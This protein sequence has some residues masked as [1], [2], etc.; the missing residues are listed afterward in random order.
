MNFEFTETRLF[1]QKLPSKSRSLSAHWSAKERGFV[2][3]RQV[4]WSSGTSLYRLTASR[5][6]EIRQDEV[7][8]NGVSFAT[9]E[10]NR[11]GNRIRGDHAGESESLPPAAPARR[12]AVLW[13]PSAAPVLTLTIGSGSVS[14]PAG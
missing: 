8:I 10:R 1:R 6:S 14:A 2:G 7:V 13:P 4:L 11:R 12:F 9:G 5:C 3:Q